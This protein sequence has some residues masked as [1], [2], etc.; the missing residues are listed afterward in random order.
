M[1]VTE[2]RLRVV[3]EAGSEPPFSA[4]VQHPFPSDGPFSK[5]FSL[6]WGTCGARN[7]SF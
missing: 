7:F 6:Q 1:K 5:M 2:R 3:T 4:Y